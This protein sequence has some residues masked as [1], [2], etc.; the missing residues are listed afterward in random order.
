MTLLTKSTTSL[1]M[2]LGLSL[3]ASATEIPTQP[4]ITKP[5][6]SYVSESD[7]TGDVKAVYD[8]IRKAYGIVPEPIKGL[9]LNPAM[10]RNTWETYKILGS[11]KNFSP[12]MTTMMRMMIAEAHQ[13]KFCVGFN[14]G[15]LMNVFKLSADE[16]ESIQKDPTS[17]KLDPKQKAMLLFMLKATSKPEKVDQTD[18]DKLKKLGWSQKDITEGVKQ[19]S[20]MVATTI[21][22]D[23]FKIM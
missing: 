9:S 1:A 11:N 7:A 13:C 4:K 2:I 21:F 5:L 16:I 17:A 18:I 20:E 8:E 19:A 15:M 23:T 3:C 22:I 10:L 14:K 6:I 12:K